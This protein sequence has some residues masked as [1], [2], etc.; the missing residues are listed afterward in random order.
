MIILYEQV[1]ISPGM[2]RC[3]TICKSI[4]LIHYINKM[5]DTGHLNMAGQSI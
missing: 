5:S 3:I 4:N 1:G 2:K